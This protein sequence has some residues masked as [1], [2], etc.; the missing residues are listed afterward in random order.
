MKRCRAC[1]AL[2]LATATVTANVLT[3]QEQELE[4]LLDRLP[5]DCE[6]VVGT[7]DAA[8]AAEGVLRWARPLIGRLAVG[9]RVTE[10]L[11]AWTGASRGLS[12]PAVAGWLENG[13]WVF[14]ARTAGSQHQWAAILSEHFTLNVEA[15]VMAVGGGASPSV[16]CAV[17][18]GYIVASTN[19]EALDKLL[20]GARTTAPSLV[21]RLEALGLLRWQDLPGA[22]LFVFS[23]SH[24]TERVVEVPQRLH[25]MMAF[26]PR[27]QR[28]LIKQFG[29]EAL[30]AG[31]TTLRLGE[32][33]IRLE[34]VAAL[35]GGDAEGLGRAPSAQLLHLP[36]ECC[37]MLRGTGADFPSLTDRLE[38]FMEAFDPDVAEEYRQDLSELNRDLGYD[39]RSHFLGS[40][41]SR[42]AAG[43]LPPDHEGAANWIFACE[44]RDPDGFLQ[45]ARQ[46]ARL[47][48]E[49][50]QQKPSVGAAR[51]FSTRAFTVPLELAL[52]AENLLLVAPSMP[53]LRRSLEVTG[54]D[55]A[56][57]KKPPAAGRSG[58]SWQFHVCGRLAALPP[59]LPGGEKWSALRLALT[60]FPPGA[61]A[62]LNIE[63]TRAALR[64]EMGLVGMRPED[65]AESAASGSAEGERIASKKRCQD[66]M[67]TI[68][69]AVNRYRIDK[70]KNP[71]TLAGLCPGYL[72]PYQL[73]CPAD[74]DPMT[75]EKNLRSSYHYVGRLDPD[76]EA[77]V[78]IAYENAGNHEGGRNVLI[79]WGRAEWLSEKQFRE[80]LQQSLRLL[81]KNN[82]DKY[83]TERQKEIEAF[84]TRHR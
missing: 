5:A 75:I 40:L 14:L 4:A 32:D 48:Q 16:F 66:N 52:A 43:L 42:W 72:S 70:E 21:Q 58:R 8:G 79:Y 30:G 18:G 71:G 36:Q 26:V 25:P 62:I 20:A 73:L 33:A 6:L 76:S 81:K 50:W 3:A 38:R 56:K 10:V 13:T 47:T 46:L 74:K 59:L 49:P 37:L 2:L 68:G 57:R 1:A 29:V 19:M 53:A 60:R 22:A 51:R 23:A 80:R 63:R 27:L 77:S 83:S 82:W 31:L 54:V 15:D 65:L 67:N 12:G 41:G 34:V 61:E 35:S 78:I 44:L 7:G 39:F 9:D 69:F 55:G 17:R 45:C 28:A 64:V 84:Y 24:A 11:D